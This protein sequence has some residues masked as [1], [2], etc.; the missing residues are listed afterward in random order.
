MPEE[1][2][3]NKQIADADLRILYEKLLVEKYKLEEQ[4]RIIH[5]QN[6]KSRNRT[7][8]LFGKMIDLKKAQKIITLQKQE[9]ERK[10][11]EINQQKNAL[12]RTF[13]KFRQ[14]TIELFGK[15]IDL[16]KAYNIIHAQKTEIETHRKLLH[17]TNASKD[18]FFTILAHDLKNPIAGFL[19][20]TEVMAESMADLSPDEQQ[21][22]AELLHNSSK[23]LYNL[24]ENLLQWA[25]SQTGALKIS[26][27]N[28]D[29]KHI[30]DSVITQSSMNARIKEIK[31][32]KSIPDISVFA[33]ENTLTTIFRNIISN[34]I[35]FSHNNS[36]IDI[37]VTENEKVAIIIVT[38]HGIGISVEDLEK[39]FKIDQ[40]PTRIGTAK[41]K[42]TG[43]GLI[44]CKEFAELNKGTI[45]VESTLGKGSSFTLTI[46]I[47]RKN[48][49]ES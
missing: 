14:R 18:R 35:K 16:K 27:K 22:F 38:D 25:R 49:V 17:E 29:L 39:L 7:I 11:I 34:A 45:K 6:I 3:N 36:T 8:E 43:L 28:T 26:P 12:E 40:N 42:G 47:A 46:P 44:L 32:T 2:P 21:H 5:R 31:F 24:L 48:M 19:G 20:L 13:Q 41:E 15:M 23:Q 4:G 9:L 30:V 37:S 33:D 10:N 1:S